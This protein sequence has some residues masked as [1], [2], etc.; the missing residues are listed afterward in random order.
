MPRVT[1]AI[2]DLPDIAIGYSWWWTLAQ[3]C[4]FLLLT[5]F[6]LSGAL[7]WPP[8][9]ATGM[10]RV[11]VGYAAAVLFGL[12]TCRLIPTLLWPDRPVIFTSR[13]GIRDTRMSKSI[14]PGN[15]SKR[16]RSAEFAAKGSSS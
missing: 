4:V 9:K 15:R 7:G 10:T 2:H 3:S 11:V 13:F 14:I 8:A 5:V 6:Y 12:G 16:S 1:T